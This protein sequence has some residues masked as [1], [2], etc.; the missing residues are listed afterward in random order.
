MLIFMFLEV[1]K[2]L[3]LDFTG[4]QKLFQTSYEHMIN[5]ENILQTISY[6]THQLSQPCDNYSGLKP[7]LSK[8]FIS[9][10]KKNAS[11]KDFL[12]QNRPMSEDF[13][14]MHK[15]V[16]KKEYNRYQSCLRWISSGRTMSCPLSDWLW[17]I[18]NSRK[19]KTLKRH[20]FMFLPI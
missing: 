14:Y 13:W 1:S 7:I 20:L 19:A 18:Y 12:D 15:G 6:Q 9:L 10:P 16:L 11:F 8:K 2:N 4:P 17:K 5:Y 3:N